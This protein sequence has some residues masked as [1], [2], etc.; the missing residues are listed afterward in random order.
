MDRGLFLDHGAVGVV[1][2]RLV[3]DLD[4]AIGVGVLEQH[5]VVG[6]GL[7]KVHQVTVVVIKLLLGDELVVDLHLVGGRVHV[8]AVAFGDRAAVDELLGALVIDVDG[9]G[10]RGGGMQGMILGV[11]EDDAV[12]GDRAGPA[13]MIGAAG[14][15]E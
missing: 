14:D 4:V 9:A 7:V 13:V 3:V 5:A 1:V 10:V 15:S 2:N 11:L 8:D 12:V 6:A